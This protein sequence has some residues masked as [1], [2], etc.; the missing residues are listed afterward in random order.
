MVV[1]PRLEPN[2]DDIARKCFQ[3]NSKHVRRVT[4]GDVTFMACSSNP[5]ALCRLSSAAWARLR[6][7]RHVHTTSQLRRNLRICFVGDSFVNG[8]GDDDFLGWPARLCADA[9]RS[10]HH[11]EITMYNLG[12]RRDTS[13]DILLRWERE[14]DARLK[15]AQDGEEYAGRLVFS[16]GANDCVLVQ[17]RRRVEEATSVANARAIL[18]TAKRKWPT[19]MV[20][21]PRTGVP[22]IDEGVVRLEGRLEEVCRGLG[23]PFLPLEGRVGVGEVWRREVAD[24]DGIHP[25]RGGYGT[26]YTVVREW[27]EWARCLGEGENGA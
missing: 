12:V 2:F 17:R 24:G 26:I 15:P 16:F 14:V 8:T 18:E 19:L 20:G 7:V 11:D 25:N 6:L 27:E 21:P 3:Y 23:V 1:E 22:K 4:G 10:N 5:M 9:K 13:T